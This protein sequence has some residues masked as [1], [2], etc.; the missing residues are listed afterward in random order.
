M[1]ELWLDEAVLMIWRFSFWYTFSWI[2]VLYPWCWF[3]CI[4]WL[5]YGFTTYQLR[6][7]RRYLFPS[8]PFNFFFFLFIGWRNQQYMAPRSIDVV[9]NIWLTQ[10]STIRALHFFLRTQFLPLSLPQQG[11]MCLLEMHLEMSNRNAKWSH[12]VSLDWL[13]DTTGIF[14]SILTQLTNN[15]NATQHKNHYIHAAY[16]SIYL[17]T[18]H[19]KLQ[20]DENFFRTGI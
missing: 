7:H 20:N 19:P 18:A 9:T 11:I 8:M 16:Q 1:L 3:T 14:T 6:D 2:E 12:Q 4:A 5:L 17:F 15:H 13:T 10:S